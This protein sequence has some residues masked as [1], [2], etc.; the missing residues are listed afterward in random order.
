MISH[1]FRVPRQIIWFFRSTNPFWSIIALVFW[2]N[3]VGG[4]VFLYYHVEIEFRTQ[5]AVAT[6]HEEVEK[7]NQELR[8]ISK[9]LLGH[10]YLS[11]KND[12]VMYKNTAPQIQPDQKF[13]QSKA[14][15]A[16]GLDIRSNVVFH[17]LFF[18][19]VVV[20]FIVFVF[21]FV[22]IITPL[23]QHNFVIRK[24]YSYVGTYVKKSFEFHIIGF[25]FFCSVWASYFL[26]DTGIIV[27]EEISSNIVRPDF[28][29]SKV[30]VFELSGFILA[31]TASIY[32]IYTK[33]IADMVNE[34]TNQLQSTVAGFF[35][36]FSEAMDEHSPN[37]IPQLINR[38]EKSI[39]IYLG[40]PVIGFFRDEAVGRDICT[41]LKR[42]IHTHREDR[43]FE[44]RAICWSPE[45]GID[46][47]AAVVH[48]RYLNLSVLWTRKLAQICKN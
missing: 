1:L 22:F 25:I 18:V 2:L 15:Q 20:F 35:T 16:L 8:S 21:E 41:I 40:N 29:R 17:P 3:F 11:P 48:K 5:N 6:T 46:Y 12:F 10:L 27:S 39:K 37:S 4:I 45:K 38:A 47:L 30:N 42:K 32:A 9:D 26:F 19:V 7:L 44:F 43:H 23:L 33:I 13:L 36:S 31:L 34:N 28:W 14:I 24:R